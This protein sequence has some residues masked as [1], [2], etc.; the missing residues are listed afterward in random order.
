MA[1]CVLHGRP[2]MRDDQNRNLLSAAGRVRRAV[3]KVWRS[4]HGESYDGRQDLERATTRYLRR[5]GVTVVLAEYGVTGVELLTPCREAGVPLVV[6]F[7]GFDA[8]QHAIVTGHGGR[9]YREMFEYARAMVA[10][11]THMRDQLL[12][13]GAP[14]EKVHVIPYGVDVRLFRQAD[15]A[16]A[17]PNFLAVG[18]FVEKKAP[19]LL[20]MAM[21]RVLEECPEACLTMIGGGPLLPVC[22]QLAAALGTAHAIDFRGPQ[23]QRVVARHMERARVFVQHSITAS[24]GDSEGTPNAI[25]EAQVA[26]VPVI[27]TRHTGIVDCVLDGENGFLVDEQDVEGMAKRMIRL[28][29]DPG[30]AGRLGRTARTLALDRFPLERSLSHLSDV[31]RSA[32]S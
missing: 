14:G 27:A 13:L 24:D 11:S 6:H 19:H 29:K 31:L 4:L 2:I 5:R 21:R 30:E 3:R 22:R 1:V 25:L 32:A 26:G 15:P 20:L 28:V 10:V 8:Y 18:R 7:H 9:R 16:S 17:P 12:A 23:D